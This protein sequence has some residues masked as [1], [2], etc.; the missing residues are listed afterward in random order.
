[1]VLGVPPG[2]RYG[3][4][5]TLTPPEPRFLRTSLQSVHPPSAKAAA[6]SI[7]LNPGRMRRRSF[8]RQQ[9]Q[10]IEDHK[11]GRVFVRDLDDGF[12]I[13][14]QFDRADREKGFA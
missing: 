9:L 4:A 3:L 10:G 5:V 12:D 6:D 1:M 8:N 13:R 14:L 2:L 11:A 7:P